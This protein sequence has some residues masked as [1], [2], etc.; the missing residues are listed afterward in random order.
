MKRRLFNL[1]AILSLVICAA[2]LVLW[3]RSHWRKDRVGYFDGRRMYVLVSRHGSFGYQADAFGA[4]G[5]LQKDAPPQESDLS[6]HSAPADD[7][8]FT[9]MVGEVDSVRELEE[10]P[11]FA[12]VGIELTPSRGYYFVPH[13]IVALS[14]ALL[15]VYLGAEFAKHRRRSKVPRG[16]RDDASFACLASGL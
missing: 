8:L 2:T 1:A 16:S 14:F 9:G 11:G 7:V 10:E 12:L 6:F 13:W 3:A 15:P 4:I 5:V